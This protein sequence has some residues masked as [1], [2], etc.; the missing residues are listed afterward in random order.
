MKIVF[1]LQAKAGQG[2]PVYFPIVPLEVGELKLTISV[3]SSIGKDVVIK[4]LR[5]EVR[6]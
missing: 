3:D 6:I 4:N 1:Y 2:T 5:V